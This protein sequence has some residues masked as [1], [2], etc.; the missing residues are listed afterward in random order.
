MKDM[1]DPNAKVGINL[2]WMLIYTPFET[3]WAGSHRLPV[4]E[5]TFIEPSSKATAQSFF[6]AH[7]ARAGAAK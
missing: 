3:S 1:R 7:T 4:G 5:Y 2:Y 6:V